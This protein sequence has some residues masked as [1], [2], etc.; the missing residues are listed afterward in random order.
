MALLD[1]AQGWARQSG[2]FL[3]AAHVDHGLRGRASRADAAFVERFC[4]ARG[5]PV[6]VRRAAVRTL[7]RRRGKGLEDAARHAR[8]A[9]LARAARRFRCP[10]VATA[11]T[12]GDQVETVFLNLLRGT[13]PAGLAGMAP[14]A[15]WPAGRGPRLLRPLLGLRREALAAHLRRRRIPWRRDETNEAPIFLRNR[16][17]PVLRRWDAERPGLFERVSRTA[18]ILR[19]EEDFWRSRLGVPAEADRRKTRPRRLE[20]G[21]FLRYSIGEQRR[22]LRHRFGLA[23][24]ESLERVRALAAAPGPGTLDL[25]GVRVRRIG[26]RLLFSYRRPGTKSPRSSLL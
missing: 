5:I 4:R 15:P 22:R 16:L 18:Q 19:D 9:A 20:V 25:P 11:H 24:F 8:Y 13:G 23:R 6:D 21:P 7:A 12:L 3:A 14:A 1:L 17:R 2:A 10:A 26:R